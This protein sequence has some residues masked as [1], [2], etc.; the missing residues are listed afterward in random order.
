METSLIRSCGAANC[1]N[2]LLSLPPL[3]T[4]HDTETII[5]H[6]P[7]SSE[8][9]SQP[10]PITR[11]YVEAEHMKNINRHRLFLLNTRV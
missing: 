6:N 1:G 5:L 10:Q 7:T 2:K 4:V 9:F 11:Y 8:E 3:S